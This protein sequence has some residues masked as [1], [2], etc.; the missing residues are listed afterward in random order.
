[1][2]YVSRNLTFSTPY[3]ARPF[4]Y[5]LSVGFAGFQCTRSGT[6][7]ELG[8][9]GVFINVEVNRLES[10]SLL[11]PQE[12]PSTQTLSGEVKFNAASS[13][14]GQYTLGGKRVFLV[15]AA[16]GTHRGSDHYVRHQYAAPGSPPD[17]Q[18][19]VIR[20]PGVPLFIPVTRGDYAQQFR[21]E[22]ERFTALE[23]EN[24]REWA[25]QSGDNS[26]AAQA[27]DFARSQAAY[28]RA[29]DDYINTAGD[30]ELARPVFEPLMFIPRDPDNP[31][32]QFRE[33]DRVMAVLNP[34]Y[35][36]ASL[37]AHVPQFIVVQLSAQ[38]SRFPWE[39]ALRE[40]VMDGLDFDAM[41]ALLGTKR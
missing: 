4:G 9:S 40:R 20:K 21:R 6:L 38:A 26:A 8:E 33:G 12:A 35:M 41:V 7:A 14:D 2:A 24:Q 23:G 17:W 28:M 39:S 34:A 11:M 25:R 37:P 32:V 3:R 5:A 15:P 31:A 10:A 16:A 13:D 22:L 29:L 27:A 36:N 18:W 1:M 30:A 19:F